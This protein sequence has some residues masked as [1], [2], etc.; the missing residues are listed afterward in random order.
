VLTGITNGS[1]AGTAYFVQFSTF[2]NTDCATTPVDNATIAFIYVNGQ[3]VSATVDPTLT[4]TIAG[5]ASG[6]TVVTGATTTV[7]S[8]STTVPLGTLSTGA[9]A[10]AAQDLTVGTNANSGYTVTAK[11]TAALASLSHNMTDVTGTNASP[12]AFPGAGTESFG[13]T[14]NDTALGTGTTGRFTGNTTWAKF[15]TSPLEV[16]YNAAA[17]SETTRIG[18]QAGIATTTAAGSYSTTVVFVATPTY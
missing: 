14:T 8:T 12:A 13:Y 18:Y 5:V 10:I 17:V 9:N 3:T 6:Q 4:F 7:T 16:A 15:T 11:Y 1:T 2:N